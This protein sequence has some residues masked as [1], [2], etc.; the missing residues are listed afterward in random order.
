[1]VNIIPMNTSKQRNFSND[2]YSRSP[3]KSSDPGAKTN[4]AKSKSKSNFN[5]SSSTPNID[6][7]TYYGG[8]FCLD[9]CS[10][11]ENKTKKYTSTHILNT[12]L[13]PKF[14]YR[15]L[16]D[17]R[18]LDC[19]QILQKDDQDELFQIYDKIFNIKS[20]S[21]Q[22]NKSVAEFILWIAK[23]RCYLMESLI[24]KLS[25]YYKQ[26]GINNPFQYDY[27]VLNPYTFLYNRSYIKYFPI[28]K[29]AMDGINLIDN[30]TP[31]SKNFYRLDRTV[32]TRL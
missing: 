14:S 13:Y 29:I 28:S 2:T 18:T 6:T 1:M 10:Y 5:L 3:Y 25:R 4:Q 30:K 19:Y 24:E 21:S 11:L 20:K 16:D 7:R 17:L 9:F 8:S 22:V 31:V 26:Y 27:Y 32:K 12:E 23:H 15:T